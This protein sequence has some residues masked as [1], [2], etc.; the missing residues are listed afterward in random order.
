MENED[1]V[2][3]QV[4]VTPT[5]IA[6]NVIVFVV[7]VL[8]SVPVFEPAGNDLIRWGADFGPLTTNGEWWRILTAVFVHVGL[9]HLLVNMAI[10]LNIGLFTERLFGNGGFT[11][12]YLL[13]GLGASLASLVWRPEMVSAG[14]SGAILGLYGGLLGFLMLHRQVIPSE[15]LRPIMKSALFFL[16]FNLIYGLAKSE[17]DMAAHVGGFATGFCVGCALALTNKLRGKAAIGI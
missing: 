9:M 2:Q 10:L 4:F 1:Q 15:V 13:S 8:N 5:V 3:G 6:I 11:L 7:M 16:G 17:V 12:L 14:A